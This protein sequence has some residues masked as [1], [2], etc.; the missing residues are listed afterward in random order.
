MD[1]VDWAIVRILQDDARVTNRER[2]SR[3]HVST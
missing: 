3:V 1:A 2:T